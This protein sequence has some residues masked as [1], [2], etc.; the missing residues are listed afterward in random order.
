MKYHVNG[1]T[2]SVFWNKSCVV[3]NHESGTTHL[4]NE[5]PEALLKRCLSHTPYDHNDLQL[6]IQQHPEFQAPDL[7]EYVSQLLL[8]LIKKDLIEQLN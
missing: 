7:Y 1:Q 4:I 6:L 5:V 2:S 3:Y 8:I